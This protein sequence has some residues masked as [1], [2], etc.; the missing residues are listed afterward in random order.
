MKIMRFLSLL[1][2]F[3]FFLANTLT[4]SSQAEAY[5]TIK[6]M[7]NNN[8]LQCKVKPISIG[9]VV[10]VP[11]KDTADGLQLN[12]SFDIKSL[13]ATVK[14]GE[15]LLELKLDDNVAM[16]NGKYIQLP[17]AMKIINNRVMV[18]VKLFENLGDFITTRNDTVMVFKPVDDKI[19]Y[20]VVSGDFLWKVAQMFGTSYTSIKTLNNLSSDTIYVG[21]QLTVRIVTAF[22]TNFD[23]ITGNATL[24]SGP[25]NEYSIVGYLV[26]GTNAKV[27]GKSGNWY[28]ISTLKG[29][30]YVYNTVLNITQNVSDTA[31]RSTF[32]QNKIPLDTSAD[33]ISYTSYTVISGD[34]GWSISEKMGLP[35]EELMSANGLTLST[36]LKIGQILKVP[37][38]NIAVK[39]TSNSSSGEVLDWYTEGQ[40]V[41]PITKTGKLVDI[42]TGLSFNI[43]RTMGASHSDTEALTDSDTQIMKQIFGGTW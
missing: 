3:T 24:R 23:A 6:V 15:N 31:P 1:I 41:L 8:D 43:Q 32:F 34:T 30:G 35:L 26:S 14:M 16:I 42:G 12:S 20:K 7:I 28:K 39:Q 5:P 40:Y 33:S 2:L 19:I 10:F 37:V 27:I 18:P 36:Y 11:L 17:G 38:H 25:G 13:T 4:Y 9:G 22:Q 21:Q 29:N